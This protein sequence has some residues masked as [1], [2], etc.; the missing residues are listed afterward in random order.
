MINRRESPIQDAY[1]EK[2]LAEKTLDLTA[3]LDA[4]AA[5]RGAEFVIIA[6]PKNYDP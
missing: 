2:Y 1:I 5:Y 3:T 6:T 4:A